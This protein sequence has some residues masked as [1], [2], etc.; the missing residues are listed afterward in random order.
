MTKELKLMDD[1]SDISKTSI[2]NQKVIDAIP[3]ELI[4]MDKEHRIILANKQ[5]YINTRLKERDV[6]GQKCHWL[7]HRGKQALSACTMNNTLKSGKTTRIEREEITN[8]TR[9]FVSVT[10]T[11]IRDNKGQIVLILHMVRDITHSK[12]VETAVRQSKH[13]YRRLVR[14]AP[15]GIL[16]ID[17]AGKIVDSNAK[18][19]QML[20]SPSAK[21]TRAVNVLD[22]PLL[23][24]AGIS[25]DFQKCID[26]GEIL[27]REREY[28]SQWGKELC[29]RYHLTPL[30]DDSDN[31]I[32]V[33][34]IVE[35]VT[36]KRESDKQ[37]K[38]MNMNLLSLYNTSSSLQ[39]VT[40]V[41]DIVDI[42]IET[43]KTMGFDRVRVYFMKNGKL[44][45]MKSSDIKDSVFRSVVLEDNAE[46]EKAFDALRSHEPIIIKDKKGTYTKLLGKSDVEISASLP[47]QRKDKMIGVIS[48]DNKFSKKPIV[49]E[50]LNNLMTFANQIATVIDNSM[51]YEEN[52]SKLRT[53]TALY[54]VSSALNGILDLSK[55]LNMIVFK[56]V[57]LLK[58]DVCSIMLLDDYNEV[59]IPKI[60]Y[61][62][63]GIYPEEKQVEVEKTISGR[64]VSNNERQYI[65]N[66]QET[67][68]QTS[69]KYLK[70]AK[71][72]SMLS[73][74]LAIENIPIGVINIYTRTI[75]DFNTEELNLMN[76]LSNQ[77][78]IIIENSKLYSKI[79][80][81]RENLSALLEISRAVNATLDKD[82]LL[83]RILDRT[84]EFTN[85]EYGFI[86]LIKDDYLKV[87][88][89]KGFDKKIT[90]KLNT[91]IG[92]GITGLVAKSRKPIIVSD[93]RNDSRYILLDEDI[94]SEAAIPLITQDKVIGVLNLESKRLDNF[95][96]FKKSL[97]ILTNQIAI[98][99]QNAGLYD[100]IQDFNKRL[101]NEIELATR[102]LRQK[103]IELLK[104]D[105]LKSDFVSNVSHELRTP[106]TSI[107]G[108]TK[109][110]V[111]EKLGSIN[112]KQRQSLKIILEEGERLTRMINNVLD[113][114]KLESGKIKFK[115]SKIDITEIAEQAIETMGAVA[116]EKE[117][118]IELNSAKIPQFKASQD[119]VK[120]VFFNLLNN[121]LKFTPKEGSVKVDIKRLK[122]KVVVSVK[123]T[124]KGIP[125][126]HIPKL[127]DK[128]FQVDSSMTREHGGSGLGLVIVKHIVDAHKGT[129]KAESEPGKGST[130]VFTLPIR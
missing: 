111:V 18:L 36:K 110:M 125:D 129:I 58:A 118:K 30:R 38:K 113:L 46:N 49:K 121:A 92:E 40:N 76:S 63:K 75:R 47:L 74:P 79:K 84:V 73:V 108:Y 107:A 81:D 13:R 109:L 88:L 112:E 16:S 57:K 65:K 44:V 95:R 32:G 85:A 8:G 91:K 43:F 41:V 83:E 96:R 68:Q 62:V 53:L 100:K 9:R 90:D 103:N 127:F 24:E 35:D 61:D 72:K 69:Y 51:L 102:E 31:I 26:K 93:V 55:I 52:Q 6:I 71:I 101:K 56:I 10:T 59:L 97:H 29:L 48:I 28:T 7:F 116:R 105:Q 94:R 123:D 11:P 23:K 130:F 126:E 122:K 2:L 115:L 64:T 33:Q 87:H 104:M 70:K 12:A 114:S 77:A 45:G 42:T 14:N 67:A 128:F 34:A 21:A 25:A 54:D 120:Q 99:I 3:D 119:L 124:G 37:L 66:I 1:L 5:I 17:T 22:F 60:V 106:L 50:D 80:G 86:M 27:V 117:I 98:A 19:V 4:V 82:M 15:L 89:S 39:H 20:G 78:A